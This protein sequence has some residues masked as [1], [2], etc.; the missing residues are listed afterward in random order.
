MPKKAKQ[1]G[2][3]AILRV[4]EIPL[5]HIL[6]ADMIS[7]RIKSTIRDITEM[8]LASLTPIIDDIDIVPMLKI[9]D[10]LLKASE[11]NIFQPT[12]LTFP[13]TY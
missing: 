12:F 6:E 4:S 3:M 11:D 2:M 7:A 10:V 5:F 9:L 8:T 1:S 13:R